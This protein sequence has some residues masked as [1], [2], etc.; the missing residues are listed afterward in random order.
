[1]E[2]SYQVE[3]AA[4][5]PSAAACVV[6]SDSMWVGEALS[7]YLELP[8]SEVLRLR[9]C[10]DRLHLVRLG[11]PPKLAIIVENDARAASAAVRAIRR[12]WPEIRVLAVGVRNQ[13]DAILRAVA[14]GVDGIVLDEESLDQLAQAARD[15]MAGVFR[16]PPQL[17]RPFFNRLV[18]LRLPAGKK[19]TRAAPA[20]V[21]LSARELDVVRCV[22]RGATNKDIAIKLGIEV[23]T[24]KNH[25]AQILRKLRVRTR[26][27]AAR[28]AAELHEPRHG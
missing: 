13:E 8:C 5:G 18:R 17:I 25:V 4:S 2:N 10:P 12:R 26:Y 28:I 9:S 21:R 20:L 16:T 7:R 24:V 23:Q 11:R 14:A 15:V 1:M 22:E 6:V 19:E 3:R 27:D